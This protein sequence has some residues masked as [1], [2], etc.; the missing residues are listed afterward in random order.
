MD[1]FGSSGVRGVVGEAMTPQFVTE[2][3]AA[4]GA[5]WDTARV[6]IGRDTRTSGPMLAAAAASGLASVGVDADRLGVL[7]TPGVA[8][9]AARESLPAIVVTASHNPPSY[10]GLKLLDAEGVELGPAALERIEDTLVSGPETVPFD[11]VGTIRSVE[12]ARRRY[13]ESVLAA[14]DREAI[15]AATLTVAVDPGHGAG[16][17]VTPDLLRELGCR[18]VTVNA[19]PDGHFPGRSPEPVPETLGA[20]GRLVAA[21]DADLGIAHDGDADRAIFYDETGAPI[22]GSA[23]LAALAADALAPGDTMVGAVNVSQRVVDAVAGAGATLALT[24]IGTT[25][26]L[27][28]LQALRADGVSAPLAGE[29]NG[30]VLFPDYRAGPDG[31]YTAVRFLELVA[32]R[33]ASELV[34]PYSDYHLVRHNVHHDSD[35]ER[36]AM[37]D[38]AERYASAADGDVN[39]LDGYRVDFEDA[40]VLARPSGTEPVVRIVAESSDADRAEALAADLRDRLT[41]ARAEAGP[42]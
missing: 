5:T 13:R 2:I 9:Y 15:A 37:L 39:T 36:A 20:L 25:H 40:W 26:I 16:A 23:S 28:R 29:G 34:A 27:S 22:D 11:I 38:A 17:V 31:A 33:A 41:A 32:D 12:G 18:V 4:A 3:A 30:G 35:A 7:P 8:E 42:D 24:P 1:V 19:Q 10:N 6:A 14:A 21:T